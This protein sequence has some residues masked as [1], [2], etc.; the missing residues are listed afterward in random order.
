MGRWMDGWT[1]GWITE[2]LRESLSPTQVPNR[3]GNQHSNEH[4]LTGA[5]AKIVYCLTYISLCCLARE[6]DHVTK[7][8]SHNNTHQ[9]EKSDVDLSLNKSCCFLILFVGV[10]HCLELANTHEL[11]SGAD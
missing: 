9:Q 5:P 7:L 3:H 10:L 6:F 2:L 11:Y 8:L 4:S 1:D